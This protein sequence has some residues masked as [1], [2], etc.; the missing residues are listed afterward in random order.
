MK[1]IGNSIIL[2]TIEMLAESMTLADKTG[3]GAES[4]AEFIKEFFPAPSAIGYSQKILNNSFSG[5]NGF[6]GKTV[7]CD[8]RK[9]NTLLT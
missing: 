4:V 6:T 3:V 8:L 1:L 7:E 9:M 5:Q 2:S